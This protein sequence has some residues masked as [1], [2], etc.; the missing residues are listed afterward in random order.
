[1]SVTELVFEL[2]TVKAKQKSDYY[3]ARHIIGMV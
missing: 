3:L 2:L 1:M